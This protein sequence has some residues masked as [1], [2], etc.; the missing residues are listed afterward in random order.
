MNSL[1][2]SATPSTTAKSTTANFPTI[3]PP[4]EAWDRWWKMIYCQTE[5]LLQA[6]TSR[7]T[8]KIYKEALWKTWQIILLLGRLLLLIGISTVGIFLFAWLLGYHSGRWS[9]EQ[10]M[11]TEPTVLM[12]FK[13]VLAILLWPFSW[14]AAW[15][16]RTLKESFGWDLKL[17]QLVPLVEDKP[18]A[19]QPGS[20]G[21]G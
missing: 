7:N 15:L 14:M 2:S 12:I 5:E 3:P 6:T 17:T 13:Q 10:L 16:D 9:R 8:G 11:A 18:A 20:G 4:A 21:K 1:P 19:D